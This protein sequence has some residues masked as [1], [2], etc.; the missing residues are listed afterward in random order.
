MG[1]RWRWY[2]RRR[3]FLCFFVSLYFSFSVSQIPL[4]LIVAAVTPPGEHTATD[5]LVSGR[6]P[7]QRRAN[8]VIATPRR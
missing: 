8:M 6:R 4:L 3:A 5:G 2:V 7:G 1:A